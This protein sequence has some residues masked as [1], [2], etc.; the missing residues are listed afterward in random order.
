MKDGHIG[1]KG[2]R[3]DRK[4]FSNGKGCREEARGGKY[5]RGRG[6]LRSGHGERGKRERGSL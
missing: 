1:S 5:S 2:E 4:K 6:G 3:G